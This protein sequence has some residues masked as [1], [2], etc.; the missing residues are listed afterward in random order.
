MSQFVRVGAE[1]AALLAALHGQCLSPA[2]DEAAMRVLLSSPGTWAL[3][4]PADDPA[5]F[6]LCRAAGGE[7][8]ILA[9]GILP[10]RRRRG[11]GRALL[12]AA[13][14]AMA[15]AGAARA[16]LEVA[17]DNAP[18][19]AL[20]AAAGFAQVGRR[21]AYYARPG[22]AGMDAFVLARAMPRQNPTR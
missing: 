17:A 14:A 6:A 1:G 18:A 2:W 11:L 7:A 9:M 21:R 3:I 10:E 16:V 22:A 13:L 15:E 8:E 19:R 5:G 12:D 4:E 20:Y